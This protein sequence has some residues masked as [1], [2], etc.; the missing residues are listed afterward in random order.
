MLGFV[1]VCLAGNPPKPQEV[2][3]EML[4]ELIPYRLE[5]LVPIS[6][7]YEEHWAVDW[8]IAMDNY[9]ESYHV[10]LGHPGLN[11]MMTPDYEDT[12]SSPGIGRG[13]SWFRPQPSSRWLERVYTKHTQLVATHVPEENRRCWRF[14]SCLPNLGI[15]IMPEQVDFFQ[16]LPNG[17]GR[18]I[19]RGAAFGVPDE[20][21]EMKLVRY[22]G[23][24]LNMQV[25]SEDRWLCERVQKGL[26]SGLYQPWPPVAPGALDARVPRPA[27]RAHPGS[28]PAE[29]PGHLRLKARAARAARLASGGAAA[30]PPR[31]RSRAPR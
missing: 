5:E 17:P 8:K 18:T 19:I 23:T 22:M 15:D 1:F 29:G 3:A 6:P 14:Y 13:T 7:M 27:A 26:R 30:A 2:W 31:P 25:N 12:R 11:R 24:K 4:E 20:R 9:L 28:T 10:P 16:V 21:R